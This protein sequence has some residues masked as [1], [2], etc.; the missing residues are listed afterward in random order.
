MDAISWLAASNGCGIAS[1]DAKFVI[2][3]GSGDAA[4]DKRVPIAV[5]NVGKAGAK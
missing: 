1:V 4:G 5:D 3:N 2:E